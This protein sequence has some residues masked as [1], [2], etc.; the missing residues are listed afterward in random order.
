MFNFAA[1]NAVA[2]IQNVDAE[3]SLFDLTWW[4]AN[5]GTQYLSVFLSTYQNFWLL[6]E[7]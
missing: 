2:Q 4:L 7:K 3:F 5:S 6:S 1:K